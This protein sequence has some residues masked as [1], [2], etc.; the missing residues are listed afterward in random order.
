MQEFQTII[1]IDISK[2]TLDIC[3]LQGGATKH[4]TIA[5]E[6]KTIKS[7]FTSIKSDFTQLYIG[8]ENTGCYNYRLYQ[9]LNSLGLTYYVIP[10]VH[11]KK[12]LGLARGKNDKIDAARIALFLEVNFRHLSAYQPRRS[13]IMKLQL[14]LTVRNQRVKLRKQLQN[15]TEYYGYTSI[16]DSKPLADLDKKLIVQIDDQIKSIEKQIQDLIANDSQLSVSYRLIITVQGVGKVLGWHLLVRTDEFKAIDSPR[17]LA[18]YAGVAP[19][20]HSSGTSIRGKNR[21][22]HYA[23]KTLKQLLHLG[24]LSAIRVTGDIRDY[25]ER[26]VAEGKNKMLVLNAVR[27]KIIHRVYAVIKNQRPYQKYLEQPLVMS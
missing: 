18:C 20:E 11:L 4:F 21:V 12:S 27:N 5:N 19:F 25:Y 9:V 6:L 1:G 24:A 26:K 13:A 3:V 17:K 8:M 7:F 15:N 22:S 23:D 10:P 14:L 2:L 16:Q